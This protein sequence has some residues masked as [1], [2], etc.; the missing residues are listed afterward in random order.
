M[1]ITPENLSRFIGNPIFN[2]DRLYEHAPVGVVMGLAFNSMGG[3][4][5]YVESTYSGSVPRF[6]QTGRLGDVM[7]ESSMIAFTYAQSILM[8]KKDSCS[9]FYTSTVHMHVPSGGTP[10]DGPSAGIAMCTSLISL[11]LGRIVPSD[12][13]MTG[14]LTLAGR[15]LGIGGLKE[16][17]IAARRSGVTQVFLPFDN[18]ADFDDLDSLI[19]EHLKVHFV[20]EYQEVFDKLFSS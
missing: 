15:I 2:S 19:T 9:D 6:Q 18:K 3:S 12:V 17:L 13:A 8:D 20:Q 5:L 14:E 16:K 11:A 1:L 4:A 10:K 7:K